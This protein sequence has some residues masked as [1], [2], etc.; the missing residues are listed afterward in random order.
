ME[1][2]TVRLSIS[3]QVVRELR[4]SLQ[5][6]GLSDV[7]TLEVLCFL[8]FLCRSFFLVW[9]CYMAMGQK[10]KSWGP[11]FLEDIFP[12]NQWVLWGTLF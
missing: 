2:A 1:T 7:P 9:F 8:F 6:G 12:F 5:S 3:A 11:Q 4:E 10:E